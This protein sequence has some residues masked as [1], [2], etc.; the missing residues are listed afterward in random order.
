[1]KYFINSKT[2]SD[3]FRYPLVAC[4]LKKISHELKDYLMTKLIEN[5]RDIIRYNLREEIAKHIVDEYDFVGS[6]G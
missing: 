3:T 2:H 5:N 6:L 4:I 1:M